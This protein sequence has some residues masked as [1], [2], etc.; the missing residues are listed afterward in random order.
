[1]TAD[2]NEP[3]ITASP[4]QKK[5]LVA[6]YHYI[7]ETGGVR[8][9][10]RRSTDGGRSWSSPVLMPQLTAESECSDPVLAYSPDGRRVFYAYMDIKFPIDDIALTDFDIIVSYSTDDGAT[11]TGPFIAL[12][13]VR[14]VFDYDKPWIGTPDDASNYVYVTATRFDATGDFACHIVFTRSTNGGTELRCAADPGRELRALWR[15]APQPSRAGLPA[16]RGQE[17]R[18]ARGVVP[19][20]I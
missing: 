3:T 9:Q 6:G 14:G 8:C 15:R 7:T 4:K 11:W 12:N 10:A 2:E 18:C 16:R 19:L 13:G 1:M 20:G 17:G 5:R